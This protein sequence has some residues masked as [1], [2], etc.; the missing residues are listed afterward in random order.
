MAGYTLSWSKAGGG[1]AP[2]SPLSGT[3]CEVGSGAARGQAGA[4]VLTSQT[5]RC[6]SDSTGPLVCVFCPAVLVL[7]S[8]ARL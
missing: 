5:H 4:G 6:C 8:S 7:T 3:D 1:Q 2:R